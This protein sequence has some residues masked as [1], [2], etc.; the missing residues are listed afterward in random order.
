MKKTLKR[1]SLLAT[2]VLLL[3]ACSSAAAPAPTAIPPTAQPTAE[4][5]MAKTDVMTKTEVMAGDAMTDTMAKTDVMTKTE[6]MADKAM[7]DTMAKTDV[8]TK[9]DAMTGDAMKGMMMLSGGDF[10][11][12][13]EAAQGKAS[14]IKT[15]AGKLEIHFENFKVTSGPNLHIYLTSLDPVPFKQ[16]VVLPDA[17][18]LGALQ[19]TSGDQTYAVP[20]GIDLTKVNTVV[21]WC[22]DFSVGFVAAKLTPAK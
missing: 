17:I 11:K 6:V 20:D 22:Q 8:M 10:Y 16:G 5:S 2:T 14:L 13:E 7:T 3:S 4:P 1:L 21:V 12:V 19:A 9:T 15:E 18:D